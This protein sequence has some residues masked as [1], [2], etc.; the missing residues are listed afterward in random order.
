MSE[1]TQQPTE[2]QATAQQG[3]GIGDMVYL[4]TLIEVVATRGAFQAGE[5]TSVGT[6]YDRLTA[7]LISNGAIQ[8]PQPAAAPAEGAQ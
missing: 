7:F 8:A 3:F 4:K 6:V 1:E 5:L 2:A